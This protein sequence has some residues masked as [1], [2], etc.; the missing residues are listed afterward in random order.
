[1]ENKWQWWKPWS[2]ICRRDSVKKKKKKQSVITEK[3]RHNKE[4]CT[5]HRFSHLS[6]WPL[7]VICSKKIYLTKFSKG[8]NAFLHKL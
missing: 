2:V 6:L 8:V 7:K 4:P 5:S 1:M 3:K